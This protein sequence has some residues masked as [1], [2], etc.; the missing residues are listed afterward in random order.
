MSRMEPKSI[1]L[2]HFVFWYIYE[3][4]RG[5]A[6]ILYKKIDCFKVGLLLMLSKKFKANDYHY[7][8]YHTLRASRREL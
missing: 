7:Y 3:G 2:I 4:F 1:N 8:Y 6:Y 5:A